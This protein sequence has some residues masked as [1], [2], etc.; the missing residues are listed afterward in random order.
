MKHYN[1][2][3]SWGWGSYLAFTSTTLCIIEE[4]QDKNSKEDAGGRS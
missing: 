1:Q 2:K 4:K 3:A